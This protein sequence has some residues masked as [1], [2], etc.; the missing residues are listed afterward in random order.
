MK[1]F[2]LS[3]LLVGLTASANA[4]F[5]IVTDNVSGI[6]INAKSLGDN[7][8][9]PY[10]FNETYKGKVVMAD[11]NVLE[12]L[13]ILY[14]LIADAPMFINM[15]GQFV[16]FNES[17]LAFEMVVS[18]NNVYGKFIFSSISRRRGAIIE[19]ICKRIN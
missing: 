2:V 11:G 4:Q 13:N 18:D 12:G 17:P 7:P 19:K 10:L 9:T 6:P 1:S 8:N 14:D 5:I 15:E 16:K 3:V